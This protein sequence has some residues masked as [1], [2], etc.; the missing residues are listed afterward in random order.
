RGGSSRLRVRG[1]AWFGRGDL[2]SSGPQ[3]ILP[4]WGAG[5]SGSNPDGPTAFPVQS[6]TA[7]GLGCFAELRLPKVRPWRRGAFDEV[8]N[9]SGPRPVNPSATL[10]SLK[11]IR[12]SGRSCLSRQSKHPTVNGTDPFRSDG[13]HRR[14]MRQL[15]G[16]QQGYVSY[17][18][19]ALGGVVI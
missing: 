7:S 15:D 6:T 3:E 9:R 17:A 19:Y 10:D 2:A 11:W 14:G 8:R 16:S 13:L 4:A 12:N 5:D 1:V 18:S